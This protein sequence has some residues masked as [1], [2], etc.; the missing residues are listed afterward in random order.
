MATVPRW[1]R[2]V[3][4]ILLCGSRA[5]CHILLLFLHMCYHVMNIG[6]GMQN[7][8]GLDTATNK[9]L[10]WTNRLTH[11]QFSAHDVQTWAEHS[12]GDDEIQNMKT[13]TCETAK[14]QSS[15]QRNIIQNEQR[16][17]QE[18]GIAQG[19][20][21]YIPLCSSLPTFHYTLCEISNTYWNR[22]F[23]QLYVT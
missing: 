4:T 16:D 20:E 23:I 12:N 18:I 21:I 1:S 19:S 8:Q 11:Q 14:S 5:I 6:H 17:K 13:T 7:F 9:K 10:S 15:N 3:V 22:L 2:S